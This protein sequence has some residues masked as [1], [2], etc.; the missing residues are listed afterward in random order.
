VRNEQAAVMIAKHGADSPIGI[1]LAFLDVDSEDAESLRLRYCQVCRESAQAGHDE[2]HREGLCR[3][4]SCGLRDAK[5]LLDEQIWC[6]ASL[7][8]LWD[9][10]YVESSALLAFNHHIF[11][12]ASVS[13]ALGN[14][15]DGRLGL[16]FY[17]VTLR[18]AV[19]EAMIVWL[20]MLAG[21]L[22]LN[23]FAITGNEARNLITEQRKIRRQARSTWQRVQAESL[24]RQGISDNEI[25]S[26]LHCSP[27]AIRDWLGPREQWDRE[28]KGGS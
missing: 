2:A 15:G 21:E 4:H 12:A 24:R 22:R 18:G 27:K 10:E 17:K 9:S 11:V 14:E 3:Y 16:G 7:S 6:A 19:H 13:P 20:S 28:H 1:C 5:R 23:V 8:A 26:R 25:A